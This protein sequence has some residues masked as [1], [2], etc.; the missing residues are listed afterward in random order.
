MFLHLFLEKSNFAY[1]K[2]ECSAENPYTSSVFCSL[3]FRKIFFFVLV[4]LC[5]IRI[6][7]IAFAATT[8]E[9]DLEEEQYYQGIVLEILSETENE[10]FDYIQITQKA[11]IQLSDDEN[12]QVT[13]DNYSI[14]AENLLE[15]NE[16]VV[17]VRS[18]DEDGAYRYIVTDPYRLDALWAV[19]ILF[20]GTVFLCAKKRGIA[21][22]LGL[23]FSI[24]VLVKF[25][26]PLISSGHNPILITV[27][28]AVII[29]V[30]SM[31]IA[32]GFEKKTIIALGSTVLTLM[33]AGILAIISVKYATLFGMGSEDAF[34]L[35]LTPLENINLKGLLIS[36]IMIASLSILDDVTTAQSAA[37]YELKKANSK[38]S[39]KE[40]YK[41]GMAIGQEH[42]SALVNT[43]FLAY[44]GA[45][46]PLFLLFQ[47]GGTTQPLWF[48]LNTEFIAEEIVRTLVASTALVLAVPITTAVAAWVY[49]NKHSV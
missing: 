44:A 38:F 42:I 33:L 37:V 26:V 17:V 4:V 20:I 39:F 43:L 27:S 40:L 25:I 8:E 15:K 11:L 45:S 5:V 2:F 36:G 34:Y 47:V 29:A 24:L 12:T 30:V 35:Q 23:L 3:M 49:R 19:L 18:I 31:L 16:K 13:L 46:L 7:P 14:R 48:T 10:I 28:G 32:H 1:C 6:S 41:R 22:L 9:V 21:A